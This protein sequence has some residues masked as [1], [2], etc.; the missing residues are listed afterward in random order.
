MS[1]E[2]ENATVDMANETEDMETAFT[3]TPSVWE[4]ALAGKTVDNA[5]TEETE[6]E[7][8]ETTDST[9][10]EPKAEESTP[11]EEAT[12]ETEETAEAWQQL[13]K[14]L[15]IEASSYDDLKSKLSTKETKFI[16]EDDTINGIEE[17]LKLNEHDLFVAYK[18][19]VEG[20][21]KEDSEEMYKALENNGMLRFEAKKAKKFFEDQKQAYVSKLKNQETEK[22]SKIKETQEHFTN[23]LKDIVSKTEK[24]Y[25]AV[26]FKP[27][28]KKKVQDYILTGKFQK[29]IINDPKKLVDFAYFTL[30]EDT[31][32]N[33]FTQ[34]GE[35]KGIRNILDTSKTLKSKSNYTVSDKQKGLFDPNKFLSSLYS[36]N[37]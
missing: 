34:Q 2:V 27:E 22:T 15:N 32:K 24:L 10:S 18:T 9:E 21:D 11:V 23:T 33:V 7:T 35:S 8:V 26:A 37:K 16:Y 4:N 5:E 25:D 17:I 1:N 12:T 28:Q 30:F 6:E 29:D 20:F 31:I 14:D 13:A 36:K 19:Y 3:L